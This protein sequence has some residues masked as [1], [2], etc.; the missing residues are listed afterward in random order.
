MNTTQFWK[1]EH[2]P[3]VYEGGEAKAVLVDIVSFAQIELILDN[4]FHRDGEPEDT[5][6]AQSAALRQLVS[7]AQQESSSANW[8]QELDEL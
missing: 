1:Q 6:L 8:K 2:F 5:L 4:L 3:M 7:R